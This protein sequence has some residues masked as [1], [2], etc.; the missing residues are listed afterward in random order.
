M[1]Q[2]LSRFWGVLFGFVR[3]FRLVTWESQKMKGPESRPQNSNPHRILA[4]R[5]LPSAFAPETDS[6]SA[7]SLT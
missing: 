5:D 1:A 6:S 3:N 7:K 2:V 4:F